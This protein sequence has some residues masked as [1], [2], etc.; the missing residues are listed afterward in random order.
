[1]QPNR[2]AVA[3]FDGRDHDVFV[4]VAGALDQ[5]LHQQRA[6]TFTALVAADVHRV[7]DGMAKAFEGAPVTE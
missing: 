5:R 3:A 7:L 2:G 1:M 4:T 6:Q